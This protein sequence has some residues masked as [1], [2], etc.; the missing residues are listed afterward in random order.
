[1]CLLGLFTPTL[2][3]NKGVNWSGEVWTNPNPNLY[4]L[5]LWPWGISIQHPDSNL[6]RAK[7][8]P[9]RNSTIRPLLLSRS[10]NH[11]IN[12]SYCDPFEQSKVPEQALKKSRPTHFV[13][14]PTLN[15]QR[16]RCQSPF[17]TG[18]IRL[19]NSFNHSFKIYVHSKPKIIP[20]QLQKM[21]KKTHAKVQV[22]EYRMAGNESKILPN[23]ITSR[24][25]LAL[26]FDIRGFSGRTIAM[27]L[28][29]VSSQYFDWT[30]S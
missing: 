25:T 1:M 30:S 9:S 2:F 19:L 28:K 18:L 10:C 6:G 8:I 3:S 24:K 16:L 22:L 14:N 21:F 29:M 13:R 26:V 5:S 17:L 20:N 15:Y 23:Q 27:Y 11:V 12:L 4:P 7:N